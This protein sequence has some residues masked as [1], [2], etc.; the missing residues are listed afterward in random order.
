M[1]RHPVKRRTSRK[2][3]SVA[4]VDR[5]ELSQHTRSCHTCIGPQKSILSLQDAR[6]W[7][8]ARGAFVDLLRDRSVVG[9]L[10]FRSWCARRVSIR[11]RVGVAFSESGSEASYRFTRI[12]SS[13]NFYRYMPLSCQSLLSLYG[14]HTIEKRGSGRNHGAASL[15][16]WRGRTA[17]FADGCSII[18]RRTGASRCVSVWGTSLAQMLDRRS[19]FPQR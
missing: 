8:V 10:Y 5:I 1:N 15:A 17:E 13:G 18:F 16:R 3:R 9:L 19:L 7:R 2:R 4:T 14:K 11:L 6:G 12:S